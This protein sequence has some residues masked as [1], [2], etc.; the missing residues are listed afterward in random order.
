[1]NCHVLKCNNEASFL[2][3]EDYLTMYGKKEVITKTQKGLCEIHAGVISSYENSS[4]SIDT[5]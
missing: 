5:L 3:K 1:M 4:V 2:M